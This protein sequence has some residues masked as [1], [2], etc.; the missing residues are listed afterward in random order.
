MNIWKERLKFTG[1]RLLSQKLLVTSL[2]LKH[3]LTSIMVSFFSLFPPL[4][5]LLYSFS[6]FFIFILVIFPII[7]IGEC[8]KLKALIYARDMGINSSII[9][10][11]EHTVITKYFLLFFFATII[12]INYSSKKKNKKDMKMN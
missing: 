8:Q 11:L 12:F 4:L 10:L 3:W 1:P 7:V 5:F 9:I 6:S 2:S